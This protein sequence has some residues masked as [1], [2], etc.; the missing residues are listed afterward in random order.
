ALAV[1]WLAGPVQVIEL[2][3]VI[4]QA[5]VSAL[6]LRSLL[7]GRTD[8]VTRIACE[9]RP[10]HTARELA[11]TRAVAWSWVWF[12]AALAVISLA[13]AFAAPPQWWRW[14]KIVSGLPLP[15]A[16]FLA[17]WLFRQWALRGEKRIG[18]RHTL[19]A[20]PRIDYLRLFQL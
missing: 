11:Y 8:I 3:L 20:L 19:R 9:I 12:M 2:T 15:V 5:T 4:V 18:L 17:E 7:G 13:F 16:F 14:W 1:L 6:F 10:A